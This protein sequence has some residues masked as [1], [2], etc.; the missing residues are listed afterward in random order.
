MPL[1]RRKL[2]IDRPGG[3][4]QTT[5]DFDVIGKSPDA[6]S[7]LRIEHATASVE[8]KAELEAFFDA[9]TRFA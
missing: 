1:T 8:I 6:P 9:F 4:K 7:F 5:I 2:T 3:S